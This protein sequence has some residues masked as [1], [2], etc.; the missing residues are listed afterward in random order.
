MMFMFSFLLTSSSM[1]AS[2]I[3]VNSKRFRTRFDPIISLEAQGHKVQIVAV[4]L[5][6]LVFVIVFWWGWNMMRFWARE[7]Y[8]V[9]PIDPLELEPA[10]INLNWIPW[11]KKRTKSETV[12]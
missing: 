8:R 5:T 2:Y 6:L 10:S 11:W 4:I 12:E 7:R 1:V 9:R 3:A